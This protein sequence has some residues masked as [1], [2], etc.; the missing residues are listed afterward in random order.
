MKQAYQGMII[1]DICE[2][3][4]AT[5]GLVTWVGKKAGDSVR[6][7]DTIASLD[8]KIFQLD[9]ERQLS[10]YERIRA[11][12][13][14]YKAKGEDD[15]SEAGKYAIQQK[16]SALNISVKDIELAKYKMDQ[17]DLKSPV[18]GIVLD[19]QGIRTGLNVTPASTPMKI[20]DMDSLRF[21]FKIDGEELQ[22][23]MA[24][25]EMHIKLKGLKDEYNAKT[26]PPLWESGSSYSIYAYFE[27]K[28][29]LYPGMAGTARV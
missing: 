6:K 2:V 10:D 21:A 11:E 28:D 3:R 20:I 7:G 4:F 25:V 9:H 29:G 27:K 5:S 8:K 24:E 19:T 17:A 26:M 14:M 23:F 22:R 13:D 1:A 15:T 12:F 16:Q 18:N